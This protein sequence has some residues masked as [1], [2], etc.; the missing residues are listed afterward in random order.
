MVLENKKIERFLSLRKSLQ[1]FILFIVLFVIK[2]V[3]L[4]PIFLRR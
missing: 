4:Q 2:R 1:K 3:H